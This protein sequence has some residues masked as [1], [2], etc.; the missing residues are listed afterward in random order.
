MDNWVPNAFKTLLGPDG[1]VKVELRNRVRSNSQETAR[2]AALDGLGIAPMV[3][4]TCWR[5]LESGALVEVLPGALPGPATFWAI[6]PLAHAKSA[7]TR[8][9]IDHL[10]HNVP[11]MTGP[12]AEDA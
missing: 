7:T 10:V 6:Y 11:G 12:V 9:F 4:M 2:K 1:P 3:E 8:A 5:Q